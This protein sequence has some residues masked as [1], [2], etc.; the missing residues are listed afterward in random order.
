MSAV[1]FA[2]LGAGAIGSVL[3]AHL[4][5]AGHS[6]V[7]LARGRRGQQ[8]E[9]DGLRIRGLAQIV[10]PVPVIVDPT[11]LPAADVLIVATKALDTAM[12]LE[13]LRR[14]RIDLAFSIQNGVMKDDLLATAFGADRVLGALANTS[15][16]LLDD[17]EVLFTRNV[18]L[19]VGEIAGGIS[20]RVARIAQTIDASGVRAA[21]VPDIRSQEWSKF[22]AWVGAV[23]V[24]V[25]T[26]VNTWR[27]FGDPGAA[28]V[29]VRLIREMTTL[30]RACG[31]EITDDSFL[32]IATLGRGTEDEAVALVLKIGSDYRAHAPDHRLS[33]LQDL[34][35]GRALE[36]EET[37][38]FAVRKARELNLSMPLVEGLYHLSAAIGRVRDPG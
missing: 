15:G 32:P 33:T 4:A 16:E 13:P 37:I 18:N 31:V 3:G 20:P 35:A 27:S 14:S 7:M 5:Q 10:V 34:E 28:R 1:E 6:V 23:A 26:R 9:R 12:S 38:G 25:T 8:V 11:A 17:G 29:L 21:A 19:L 36:L 22:V 24:A 2:I 30:A